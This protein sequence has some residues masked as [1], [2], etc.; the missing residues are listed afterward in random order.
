MPVTPDQKEAVSRAERYVMN[1]LNLRRTQ[2][3]V[4]F[5]R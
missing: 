1:V 5:S 3:S 2:K 4:E